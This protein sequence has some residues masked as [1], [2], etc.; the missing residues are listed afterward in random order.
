[1]ERNGHIHDLVVLCVGVWDETSSRS[2]H[3]LPSTVT[4]RGWAP[5]ATYGAWSPVVHMKKDKLL[6]HQNDFTK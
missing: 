4:K 3:D 2:E 5:V 1:M 6:R